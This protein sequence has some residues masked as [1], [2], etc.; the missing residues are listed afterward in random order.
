MPETRERILALLDDTLHQM[1][2]PEKEKLLWFFDGFAA[3]ARAQ[4]AD[5]DS[6]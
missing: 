4:R 5:K 2:E 1:S 6:A 3:A